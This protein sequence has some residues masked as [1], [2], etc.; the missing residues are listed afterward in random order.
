V[1]HFLCE[2][3]THTYLNI[4]GQYR[5]LFRA[6]EHPGLGRMVTLQEIDKAVAYARQSGMLRVIS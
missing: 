4:M 3:S 5:P 6:H 1:I 2:L